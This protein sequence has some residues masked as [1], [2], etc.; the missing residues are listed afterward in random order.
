MDETPG[1][2][3]Q[4]WMA[5]IGCHADK[6]TISY[7]HFCLACMNIGGRDSGDAIATRYGPDGSWYKIS[8]KARFSAV[9]TCSG[10]HPA[11]STMGTGSFPGVKLPGC[12]AYPPPHLQCRGL[13]L[14]RAIPLPALR[15][16]VACYRESLL[17]L[18]SRKHTVFR[19]NCPNIRVSSFIVQLQVHNYL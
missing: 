1:P 9:R 19:K 17:S 12:G 2:E 10:D 13:K 18:Y 4:I 16:L 5:L 14:G 7:Q 11:S 3:T 15:A 6:V 8:S